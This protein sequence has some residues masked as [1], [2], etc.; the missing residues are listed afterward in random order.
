MLD[1]C[2]A[3]MLQ[4]IRLQNDASPTAIHCRGGALE[5]IDLP[6]NCPQRCGG[7]QAAQRTTDDQ[8]FRTIRTLH[9]LSPCVVVIPE[10]TGFELRYAS[11]G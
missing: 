6:A 10:P 8:G 5:N 7:K 11:A 9:Y 2:I 4:D 1:A 3:K